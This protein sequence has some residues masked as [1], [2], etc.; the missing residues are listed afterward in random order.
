M[1]KTIFITGAGR[2][3]TTLLQ[4]MLNKHSQM[5][6]PPEAHIFTKLV[7]PEALGLIP[8]PQT[9]DDVKD[10]LKKTKADRLTQ[11]DLNEIIRN[12][13]IDLPNYYRGL[14]THILNEYC[15]HFARPIGGE[16]DPSNAFSLS[17]T[18]GALPKPAYILHIYRDPRDIILSRRKVEWDKGKSLLKRLLEYKYSIDNLTRSKESVSNLLEIKYEEL[19]TNTTSQLQQICLFI[20]VEFEEPMLQYHENAGDI[21]VEEEKRWK[22]NVLK[23]LMRNNMQKW[24]KE[25]S[26]KSLLMIELCVYK[27]LKLFKY[28]P[29]NNVLILTLLSWPFE[30]L[31]RLYKARARRLHYHET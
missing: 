12:T 20:G 2:S 28:E 29:S 21:F 6:F 10:Q 18:Y 19:L 24:K 9:H 14:F 7:I 15:S 3:G 27:E 30:L 1:E 17:K 16:K 23:P 31:F 22:K 26:R 11:I 5:I 4:A 8:P 25:I 13:I